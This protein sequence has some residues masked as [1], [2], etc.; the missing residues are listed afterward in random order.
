MFRLCFHFCIALLLVGR[1]S[2]FSSPSSS[3]CLQG[4][5]GCLQ[6]RE[7]WPAQTGTH[8]KSGR[9]TRQE[10]RKVRGENNNLLPDQTYHYPSLPLDHDKSHGRINVWIRTQEETCWVQHVS[11]ASGRTGQR[12]LVGKKSDRGFTLELRLAY[13]PVV[14]PSPLWPST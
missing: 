11:G 5:P 13:E 3:V 2:F 8:G 14:I 4:W 7:G 6:R 1:V 12:F 10:G 9:Q